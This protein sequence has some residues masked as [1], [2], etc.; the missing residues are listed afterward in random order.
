MF[1][2]EKQYIPGNRN[3][4]LWFTKMSQR[5]NRKPPHEDFHPSYVEEI[6]YLSPLVFRCL[7]LTLQSNHWCQLKESPWKTVFASR[8]IRG[9]FRAYSILHCYKAAHPLG[10]ILAPVSEKEDLSQLASMTRSSGKGNHS[11]WNSH[12]IHFQSP[13]PQHLC[14]PLQL[15]EAA[16]GPTMLPSQTIS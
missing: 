15:Q 9:R 1:H 16:Q 6:I 10:Q 5:S 13:V 14:A 2:L 7:L 4:S 8:H 12:N 11:L 3:H